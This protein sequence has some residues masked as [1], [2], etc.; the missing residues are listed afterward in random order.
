MTRRRGNPNWGRTLD[1]RPPMPV[2]ISGWDL[3]LYSLNLS[4]TEALTNPRVREYVVKHYR[5]RF[6]PEKVLEHFNLDGSFF[7]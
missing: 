1:H 6:V 5:G 2:S 7:D 4:Q 3:L